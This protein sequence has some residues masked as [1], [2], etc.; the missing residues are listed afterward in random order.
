MYIARA[1][2]CLELALNFYSSD[3]NHFTSPYAIRRLVM[4]FE[5]DTMSINLDESCI[6]RVSSIECQ[7]FWRASFYCAAIFVEIIGYWLP[8]NGWIPYRMVR[9]NETNI[10]QFLGMDLCVKPMNICV[11]HIM[12]WLSNNFNRPE[13]VESQ[14]IWQ[15]CVGFS[16]HLNFSLL[17]TW[18]LLRYYTVFISRQSHTRQHHLRECENVSAKSMKTYH[19]LSINYIDVIYFS[20]HTIG[21][22][23]R[24]QSVEKKKTNERRFL[25]CRYLSLQISESFNEISNEV[26]LLASSIFGVWFSYLNS[27]RSIQSDY[28]RLSG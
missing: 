11:H 17:L 10:I 26:S 22:K 27:E 12:A 7:F 15:D 8:R 25:N 14:F 13:I 4:R 23:K 5:L 16:L 9:W 28:F 1:G 2:C 21:A 3:E 24:M 18:I 20:C 6:C 19:K